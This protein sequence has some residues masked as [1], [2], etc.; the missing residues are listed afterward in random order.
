MDED[1]KV[2]TKGFATAKSPWM[3]EKYVPFQGTI[4]FKKPSSSDKGTLVLKKDNPTGLG[5]H[6][7]VLAIPVFLK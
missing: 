5:E 2:I 4:E 6:D 1:G 3:T 7:D